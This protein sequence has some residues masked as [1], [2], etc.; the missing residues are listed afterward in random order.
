[1]RK[2]DL[3]KK[4]YSFDKAYFSLSDLEK[5]LDIKRTSLR[6]MVSRLAKQGVLERL[7]RGI[8]QLSLKPEDLLRVANQLYY[9]SYISFEYALGEYGILSEKPFVVTLATPKKSKRITLRNTTIEFRQIKKELFFGFEKKEGV[10]WGEAEKVLLDQIYFASLGKAN[11]AFKELTLVGLSK[12]K[13]LAFARKYPKVVQ[14]RV[15][16]E[17]LPLLGQVS[18]EVK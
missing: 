5:L 7:K 3:I 17:L 6:V 9:P 14:K 2:T 11:I 18:I 15:R 1:M 10:F 16:N 13:L 12:K 8:Y 4:L